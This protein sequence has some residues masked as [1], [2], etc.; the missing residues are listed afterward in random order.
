MGDE[1][2]VGLVGCGGLGSSHARNVEG[3]PGARLVAVY[4]LYREFSERLAG[5]LVG[6]PVAYFDHQKML[7]EESLDAVLVVTTNDTHSKISVDA[8][9]AGIHVFCEKPMALTVAD[10]DAMI[11]AS[12][13]AQKHLMVGYVRRFQAAYQ[14]MK[15]RVESGEI[16]EVTMAHAVRLGMGPPGGQE[17]WQFKQNRYGGLFS[18]Y[19]HELDQLAWLGGEIQAVQAMMKF[20]DDPDN[21][22]EEHIFI[23]LEFLSGAIGSMSSSRTYPV[24]SY[25]LGVAGT[26]GAIKLNAPSGPLVK[27]ETGQDAVEIE[28]PRN[29]GLADEMTYFLDCIRRDVKPEPNGYD[30]RRVVAVALAAHQ[31]AQSGVRELVAHWNQK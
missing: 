3:I 21:D 29:N 23:T 9:S 6:R 16:G 25:E 24:S 31:S 8:L 18:I 12:E 19:S 28:I 30:G 2:R 1:L 5:E 15:S 27:K 11:N 10:C 17:G 7:S 22:I 4:D 14:E 26:L 13:V 20:G